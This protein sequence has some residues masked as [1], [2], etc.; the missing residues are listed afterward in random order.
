M[1][2]IMMDDDDDDVMTMVLR[3]KAEAPLL[4]DGQVFNDH[5]VSVDIVPL[6]G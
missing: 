2:Q 1:T 5:D 6:T 4:P 3:I